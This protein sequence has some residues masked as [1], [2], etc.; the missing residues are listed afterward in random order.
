[1]SRRSFTEVSFPVTTN[2]SSTFL[3]LVSIKSC[4]VPEIGGKYH[5]LLLSPSSSRCRRPCRVVAVADSNP[6]GV[7]REVGPR[8]TKKAKYG[9]ELPSLK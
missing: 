8:Y 5:P 2:P 7:E 6:D 4:N 1:M 9:D 3:G